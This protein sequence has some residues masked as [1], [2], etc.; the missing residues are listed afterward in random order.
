MSMICTISTLSVQCSKPGYES[1]PRKFS[2]KKPRIEFL[3]SVPDRKKCR[4]SSR[5]SCLGCLRGTITYFSRSP[6]IWACY[7][8][9][10]TRIKWAM[11]TSASAF[12]PASESTLSAF[13]SW[14]VTGETVGKDAG[15]RRR[16]WRKS[17][18]SSIKSVT[19][20]RAAPTNNRPWLKNEIRS[21]FKAPNQ[22]WSL[23]PKDAAGYLHCRWRRPTIRNSRPQV[24]HHVDIIEVL[25]ICRSWTPSNPCRR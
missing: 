21:R 19:R 9:T 14:S 13:N 24:P 3:S 10:W 7:M 23:G 8:P 5:T 11:S 12:N 17:I 25:L 6:V 22:R 2:P 16:R 1:C 20:S 4:A 15:P 18:G